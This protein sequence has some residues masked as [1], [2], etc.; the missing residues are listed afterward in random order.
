MRPKPAL[1]GSQGRGQLHGEAVG[2]DDEALRAALAT[3]T[4]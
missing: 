3:A 1:A 2:V 4:R